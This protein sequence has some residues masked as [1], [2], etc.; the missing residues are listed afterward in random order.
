MTDRA[1][2]LVMLG[3]LARSAFETDWLTLAGLLLAIGLL[4]LREFS[5]ETQRI[6]RNGRD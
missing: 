5:D 4:G 3:L 6:A 2:G 1:L